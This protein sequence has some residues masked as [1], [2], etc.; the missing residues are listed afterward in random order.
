M[1]PIIT[2]S[3]QMDTHGHTLGGSLTTDN[4]I[5]RVTTRPLSVGPFDT[6][7]DVLETAL[8]LVGE[9]LALW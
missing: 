7:R 3:I 6:P 5:S 4:G 9:Q 1:D 2:I 8:S